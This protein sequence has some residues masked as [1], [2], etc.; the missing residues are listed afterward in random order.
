M[1]GIL[2]QVHLL[3]ILAGAFFLAGITWVPTLIRAIGKK[4]SPA[5]TKPL[6]REHIYRSVVTRHLWTLLVALLIAFAGNIP[7]FGGIRINLKTCLL[8]LLFLGL[9]HLGIEPLEWRLA[10]SEYRRKIKYFCPQTVKERFLFIPAT[11]ATALTEEVVY[12]AVF[13]GILYQI[14][15]NY[16]IACAVSVVFFS[17]YHLRWSLGAVV[18]TLFVGVG[19]HYLVFISGG[20]YVPIVVHF[21]HNLINGVIYGRIAAANGDTERALPSAQIE[22]SYVD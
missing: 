10:S 17:I 9:N 12:R 5:Q 4:S 19:L 13:F 8:A 15:G 20:L 22:Q 16:W 1:E 18:T 2:K 7:V 6:P 14:T 21:I 3:I 11:L